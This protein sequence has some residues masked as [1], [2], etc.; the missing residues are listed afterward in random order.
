LTPDNRLR[1]VLASGGNF[2]I[3]KQLNDGVTHGK[4]PLTS[5]QINIIHVSARK[6]AR[7]LNFPLEAQRLGQLG[8]KKKTEARDGLIAKPSHKQENVND[9]CQYYGTSYSN[10]LTNLPS[11]FQDIHNR[12]QLPTKQTNRQY[13]TIVKRLGTLAAWKKLS[14][15]T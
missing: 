6:A 12:I 11:V 8:P 3:S 2:R 13:T 5:L 10:M 9:Q 1:R 4:E 7:E 15:L 14:A